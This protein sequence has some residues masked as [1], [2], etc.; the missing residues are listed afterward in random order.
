VEGEARREDARGG[1]GERAL[2][3]GLSAPV[4]NPFMVTTRIRCRI[5]QDPAIERDVVLTIH[6]AAGRCVCRLTPAH[7]AGATYGAVWDG[8]DQGGAALPAGVYYCH[9][10]AGSQVLTRP[11]IL[12]R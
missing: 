4:P 12:V 6:D 9:L 11:V 10:A 1:S 3:A 2:R 5:P 7:H 8:A